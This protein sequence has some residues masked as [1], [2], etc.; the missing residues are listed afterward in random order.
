MI[1]IWMKEHF[2]DAE[3]AKATISVTSVVVAAV[4]FL[5]V[6]LTALLSH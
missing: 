6:L 4:G 2:K 5:I 1:A 3:H